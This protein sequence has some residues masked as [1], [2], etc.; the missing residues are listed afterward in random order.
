MHILR[1]HRQKNHYSWMVQE[2]R[3]GVVAPWVEISNMEM[4]KQCYG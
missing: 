3:V 2:E 1:R 4:M